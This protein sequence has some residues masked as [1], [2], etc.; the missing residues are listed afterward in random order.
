MVTEADEPLLDEP[1]DAMRVV[2]FSDNQ[3]FNN[4]EVLGTPLCVGQAKQLMLVYR[5][6][7]LTSFQSAS[8]AAR[9]CDGHA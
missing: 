5:L 3:L 6:R 7:R 1:E 2:C 9:V 8:M 4:S